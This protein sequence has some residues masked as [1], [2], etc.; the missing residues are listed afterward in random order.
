MVAL[1]E[2]FDGNQEN[3]LLIGV[4]GA[5]FFGEMKQLLNKY[6]IQKEGVFEQTEFPESYHNA[7]VLKAC[8]MDQ[9]GDLDIFLGNQSISNDFG[10]TPHSL[11]MENESGIFR[12]VKNDAL[13]S[14]GMI[15]DA[16]WSDVDGDGSR[17][18]IVVGE[19]MSPKI[20]KNNSGTLEEIDLINGELNG[21]WQSIDA[22]DIDN[23]GDMDFV[24]GNWGRNSKFKASAA[25][26]LKM[27]YA[28]FDDNGSTET[29]VALEKNGKYYPIEDLDGLAGQMI[30]LKKKFTKYSDFAGRT[31][32]EIID[33]KELDKAQ[34]FEVQELRSG[35]LLNEEGRFRFVPFQKELQMAPITAFLRYDFNGDGKDELLVGGNYFGVKPYHGRFG[36]FPG[37][38]I[39]DRNEVILG[40]HLDLISRRNQSGNCI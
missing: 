26:P 38:V 12:E 23:D 8:D 34:L 13:S 4:G 6:F 33:R 22:F 25:Y 28:D 2:D 19:W 17:D 9:D 35:Y 5:D 40:H 30:S 16:I 29:V 37:A 20:F 27:Y 39:T 18:L 15:T 3:D 21:L 31:V 36:T 10:N 1:I 32:E 14:A 7:S 11:L 24:L